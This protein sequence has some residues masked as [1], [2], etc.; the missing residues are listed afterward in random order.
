[1]INKLIP[2]EQ[3]KNFP[4]INETEL[5]QLKQAKTKT[6]LAI[7]QR[8]N[9]ILDFLFYIGTRVSELINIRHCDYANGLL[10]VKGKGNKIRHVLVPDFLVK[11]FNGSSDYLFKNYRGEKISDT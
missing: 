2:V 11:Y 10:K 7:N 6:T 8:N 1:M 3:Q 9:L 5:E 4:T